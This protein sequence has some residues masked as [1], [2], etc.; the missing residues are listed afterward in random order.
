MRNCGVDKRGELLLSPQ[1]VIEN[2]RGDIDELEEV[3][4][5]SIFKLVDPFLYLEVLEGR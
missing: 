2:L 1:V 4:V 3:L 5:L